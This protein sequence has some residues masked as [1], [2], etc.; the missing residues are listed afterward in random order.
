MNNIKKTYI[1]IKNNNIL[2][3]VLKILEKL[4]IYNLIVF[5]IDNL[6][7]KKK[8][9][10]GKF[11]SI[12]IDTT[13]YES[14]LCKFGGKYNTDKSQLNKIGHRHSYTAVYNI[15]FS[16]L[17]NKK[18]NLAEIGIL[19]NASIKMWRE[20]FTSAKIVGFDYDDK[21]ILKA[22]KDKLRNVNYFNINVN[23]REKITKSFRKSKLKYDI[24]IDDST[25]FFE[26]QINIINVVE[27]FLKKDGILV[28]EDIYTKKR[29]YSENEYFEKLKNLKKN[30][31][32]IFF[33][34]C[35]HKNNYSGLW[36]NHK[37]LFFKK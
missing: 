33:V 23:N 7:I 2:E 15:I 30:F 25:H 1:F 36:S 20:Y 14:I 26:H 35:K 18:I 34:E 10:K 24:I 16:H 22:K 29:A 31:K 12:K 8:Y 27:K 5:I 21:L 3:I 17:K 9:F 37:L 32:D 19:D 6:D 11:N 13:Q 4:K 28:I